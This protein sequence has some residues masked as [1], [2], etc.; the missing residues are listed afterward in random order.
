MINDIIKKSLEII[1]ELN[2]KDINDIKRNKYFL[3]SMS[4]KLEKDCIDIRKFLYENVYNHKK[5]L[6]KKF[7][8]E[9]IILKIFE[10][11]EKN[12]ERLPKDWLLKNKLETKQS[13]ICDY[14]SGMTDRYASNLYRSLYE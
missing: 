14:I 6:E 5:L 9:N 10:Y 8:S 12:F 13:I 1:K 11:Y 2:I 7:N 4:K 3:I